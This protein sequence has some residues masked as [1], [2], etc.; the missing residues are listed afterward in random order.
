MFVVPLGGW[1]RVEVLK[2]RTKFDWAYQVEWLLVEFY[3]KV[4]KVWLVLDN[5]NTRVLGSLYLVFP[6]EKVRSLARRLE[7]HC[8]PEHGSWFN[9]AELELSALTRQ[10]LDGRMA[11]IGALN[12]QLSIWE[13]E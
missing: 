5:L 9:V 2:R 6:V 11:D 7:F 13:V 1:R 4:E 12:K 8:T 3:L 10:C